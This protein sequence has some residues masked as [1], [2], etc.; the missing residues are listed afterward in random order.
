MNSVAS[1]ILSPITRTLSGDIRDP[2]L[3]P[4]VTSGRLIPADR[5]AQAEDT[6]IIR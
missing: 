3:H 4:G 6:M 5:P 2:I 1:G